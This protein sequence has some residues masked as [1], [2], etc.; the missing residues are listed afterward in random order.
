MWVNL[1]VQQLNEYDVMYSFRCV[2]SVMPE[3]LFPAQLTA[4]LGC[5]S[6]QVLCYVLQT[7]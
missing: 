5:G 7:S 1:N 4:Q 2:Y 3:L 6:T